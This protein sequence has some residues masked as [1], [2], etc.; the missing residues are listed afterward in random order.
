MIHKLSFVPFKYK[1]KNDGGTQMVVVLAIKEASYL[2]VG[3]FD[4][5]WD[6]L[7]NLYLWH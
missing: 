4:N 5:L 1:V 7:S 6:L 2:A 3:I